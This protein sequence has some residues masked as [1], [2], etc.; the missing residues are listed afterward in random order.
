[1]N[2]IEQL[3][4][5][6]E[7]WTGMDLR[8]TAQEAALG[9]FVE[10]RARALGIASAEA[11]A[12]QL[13]APDH[14]EVQFLVDAATVGYTWFFRDPT[15][16]RVVAKLLGQRAHAAPAT[17]VWVPGCAT[18][19][20]AYS[21]AIL[22][23]AHGR[24]VS[25]L[26]TDINASM[27]ADARAARYGSWSLRALGEPERSFFQAAPDGR[28][29]LG[30]TLRANV[31]FALH[32]LLLAPPAPPGDAA[33]WD[34]ILCRNVLIYFGRDRAYTTV[35][36]L[37]DALAPG[38][39][40]LLGASEFLPSAPA[41]LRVERIDDR[42]VLRR[43]ASSQRLVRP[44]EPQEAAPPRQEGERSSSVGPAEQA[45]RAGDALLARGDLEAAT[46]ILARACELDALSADARLLA[47]IARYLAGDARGAVHALRGAA[48][49][50][51]EL[52]PAAYYL[53]LCH[54]KLG[55]DREARLQFA[56]VAAMPAPVGSRRFRSAVVEALEVYRADLLLVSRDRARSDQSGGVV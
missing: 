37:G 5:R 51:P 42:L 8:R 52:W 18:G 48:F 26:A 15:Q 44:V 50:D 38:G 13:A 27:L 32:N 43:P 19:E 14:P 49:L 12:A 30:E 20:D 6:L 7:E 11:Y 2:A 9:R 46:A 40:L 41:G 24:R 31:T 4:R 3:A 21:I 39:V 56:R 1:M 16:L 23:R 55:E 33:G 34:L 35:E 29:E 22:A 36:R 25:I 17:H 45:L 28:L 47:G 10:R 54:Q 53:A